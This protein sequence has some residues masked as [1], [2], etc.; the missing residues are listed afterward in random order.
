MP[1]YCYL[2]ECSDG[3]FYTGWSMDPIKRTMVHNLGRG[4]RYTRMHRP[5][6]LVYAEE[7]PDKSSALR[8]ERAIKK[9]DH[10][11]KKRLAASFSVEFESGFEAVITVAGEPRLRNRC[12]DRSTMKSFN[13]QIRG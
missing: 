10:D 9:L 12:Y 1:Y 6:K 2:V 5:V 4:A 3:S 8:R 13:N 11:H 7:V